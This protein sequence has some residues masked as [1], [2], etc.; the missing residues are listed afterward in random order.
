MNRTQ[1]NKIKSMYLL[2]FVLTL[3]LSFEGSW[4]R[5]FITSLYRFAVLSRCETFLQSYRRSTLTHEHTIIFAGIGKQQKV[6]RPKLLEVRH[7]H[8]TITRVTADRLE[9]VT[10]YTNVVLSCFDS[11]LV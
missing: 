3:W 7:F 1:N 6:F 11:P 4:N 10:A 8:S 9:I 5:S 2:N